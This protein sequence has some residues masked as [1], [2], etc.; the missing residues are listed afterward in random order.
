LGGALAQPCENFP[1]VFP[2][3]TIFD[4][5]PFLLPNLVCSIILVFGVLIG[6]LFLEETHQ[7]KKYERDMG[8]EAGQW[9]L[10]LFRSRSELMTEKTRKA[11]VAE[12]HALMED[13]ELPEYSMADDSGPPGYRTTEGSPRQSSSRSQSR[14]ASNAP[15]ESRGADISSGRPR[16]VKKAFTKQVILTIIAFGILA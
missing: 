9:I 12:V 1:T 7:E 15:L 8:T 13:E 4:D 3:G 14:C 11:L 16:G 6:I 10:S 5:Y 2:R